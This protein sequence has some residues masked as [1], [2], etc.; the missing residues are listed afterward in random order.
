MTV[1]K[2]RMQVYG[3]PYK[4]CMNCIKVVYREE[5]AMAF[6]RS[7]TTQLTMNIP[8][9][10]IHFVT[11]E[12]MQNF[13]NKE[14]I[15][16]PC[17]HMISGG[18][19]GAAAAFFTMPLDV[20][21][22]LLNTQECCSRTRVTYISGMLSAGKLVY[23]YQ[24]MQGYFRGVQARVIFQMPATGISWLVYELFKHLLSQKH[25]LDDT[26]PRVNGLTVNAVDPGDV[27]HK[28]L[29]LTQPT[30]SVLTTTRVL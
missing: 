3:S 2:Q 1:V 16:D 25:N 23:E 24:G 6:Y 8:F 17:S 4:S 11:Y 27:E 30:T 26:Y 10:C 18:I 9:Q 14:R 12:I 13:M 28:T 7:F 22:T 5:G 19:A 21:K 15:Y 20:C 29:N